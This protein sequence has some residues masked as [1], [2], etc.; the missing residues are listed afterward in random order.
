MVILRLIQNLFMWIVR[1][2]ILTPIILV[3]IWYHENWPSEVRK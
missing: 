2:F 1:T 3:L